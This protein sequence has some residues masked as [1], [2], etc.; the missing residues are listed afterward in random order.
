MRD[1]SKM[2]ERRRLDLQ[3]ILDAGRSQAERNRLGQ[4]ATP[5]ALADEMLHLAKS[6]LPRAHRMRFLD[7]AFGTG[8]FYSALI[9]CFPKKRIDS[10]LGFEIDPY[11]GRPASELWAGEG[12]NLVLADFTRVKPPTRDSEKAGL[13]VCN[14]PYVRHHH[15]D[16]QTKQRLRSASLHAAGVDLNGLA[17]LYCHF[18]CLSHA[19]MAR[20]ALAFWLIPSEF[21]DVNYGRP[22]KDYL[23]NRV[24]LLR[25]QRFDPGQVQFD[26]AL[27]SSAV[28]CFRNLPASP[29]HLVEFTYG[30]TLAKP[31]RT[32]TQRVADLDPGAKWSRLA[33]AHIGDRQAAA[34]AKL[35]DLFE[36][37]RG[38]ATG[39]NDF[40]IME[41]ARAR[42]LGI[43][44]K[45]LKPI[46]PSPRH[47]R[48]DEI[49]TD[50]EGRPLIEPRLFLLDCSS[51]EHEVQAKYPALWEYLCSGAARGIPERYLCKHRSPWYSQENR[52]PAPIMCTYM[53]RCRQGKGAFRFILNRS[54]AIAANVYLMLYPRTVLD[55]MMKDNPELLRAAWS[56]LGE[57]PWESLRS[58][59]R[60]Y[61]GGLHKMEPKE[62]AEAP[63][64]TVLAVL[65]ETLSLPKAQQ[66]SL[67][68]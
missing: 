47:L 33:L 42:D 46:L 60:V 40:F 8:S 19:W 68:W 26:D 34:K 31:Q 50:D 67:S 5:T 17:G 63:A 11:Y 58:V 44:R 13:V 48:T 22:L 55:R 57:I 64:D 37:K 21:M 59:G 66:L 25:I 65:P 16:A 6:L 30:G 3:K 38:V 10:A 49:D 20:D 14:P 28:V 52:Q 35:S 23:L 4:F 7:P 43:P 18:V 32:R 12:L 15:I 61:G 41:E 29:D 2:I 9:R 51:P 24:T 45:F 27:V 62:L 53:G 1:A 56:A 54:K 36:V 39:A